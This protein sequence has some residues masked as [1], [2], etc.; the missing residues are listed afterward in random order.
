LRFI[1]VEVIYHELLSQLLRII[2]SFCSDS[3]SVGFTKY[4]VILVYNCSISI[5]RKSENRSVFPII[6]LSLA[7]WIVITASVDG[8]LSDVLPPSDI[9]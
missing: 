4:S 3:Y 8:K 6:E 1:E 5:P 9:A 7:S 2:C